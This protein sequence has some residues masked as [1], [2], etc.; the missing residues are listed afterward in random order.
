MVRTIR[1][2]MIVIGIGLLLIGGGC[3][4][5]GNS[6]MAEQSMDPQ[7]PSVR[8]EFRAIWVATVA[9]IDWPSRAGLSTAE[10]QA[11][12][13]AILDSAAAMNMNAIILQIRP[14]SDA[15]YKS[16]LEP[17]S[18]YLTGKQGQAPE[19]Y[20][21]PLEF[22]ITQAHQRGLELHAWMNPYR[23]H[24][25]MG[26]EVTEHTIVKRQ[27]ELIHR[28]QNGMYWMDP[29]DPRTPGHVMKV[30]LDVIRRYDIDGIQFDDYFY[31]YAEYSQGRDF[32]D[33]VTWGQ[34]RSSGGKLSRED[35]RREN[36]NQFVR[37]VY[38]MIKKEKKQVRFGISPFGF[39]KPGYPR[40]AA[41]FSQHDELYADARL[42]IEKGWMDYYIPQIYWPTN[43]MDLSFPVLLG[44]WKDHNQKGRH[45]WPGLDVFSMEGPQ[46]VQEAVRQIMISRGMESEAPGQIY[47]SMNYFSRN[48]FGINDS[49]RSG[50]YRTQALVPAFPWLDK[51]KPNPPVVTWDKQDQQIVVKWDKGSAP[52]A[53]RWIIYYQYRQNWE[54]RI[55]NQGIGEYRLEAALPHPSDSTKTLLLKRFG[56]SAVSCTGNESQCRII[57]LP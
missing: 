20:Y 43:H 23:A 16:E 39:W 6:R 53:F 11:E 7:K 2:G 10:Q 55:L 8:R 52:S 24:H 4:F 45:L 25:T 1:C 19:P 3:I 13:V 32:P 14:Q 18:Y 30:V 5:S 34:Y 54:Y 38:R 37:D 48:L 41:G 35:W 26:G 22:W 28:M 21:D 42:W 29:G 57:D 15:F 51:Q 12:V 47:Y 31:P 33:S 49:L 36:V 46:D 9:N 44:W 40:D 56:V 50:P 27:P 17:W